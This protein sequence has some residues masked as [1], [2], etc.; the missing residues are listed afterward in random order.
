MVHLGFEPAILRDQDRRLIERCVFLIGKIARIA[1]QLAAL[2]KLRE[3]AL[4][5]NDASKAI[6]LTVAHFKTILHTTPKVH[7]FD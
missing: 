3:R 2:S 1:P 4:R 5:Y 7:C 6:Q